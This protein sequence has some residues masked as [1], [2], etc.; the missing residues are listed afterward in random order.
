MEEKNQ[1]IKKYLEEIFP[2]EEIHCKGNTIKIITKGNNREN[3]C[4]EL[5]SKGFLWKESS[6]SSLGE[7]IKDGIKILIKP[8]EYQGIL[9][10]G[11]FNEYVF[12][13][14]INSV[15][16][17]TSS[18]SVILSSSKY[19]INYSNIIRCNDSSQ[20]NTKKYQKSD[21]SLIGNNNQIVSNIS[22]KKHKSFWESCKNRFRDIYDFFI[23][24]GL[25]NSFREIEFREIKKDKYKL[26]NPSNQQPYSRIY[27]DTTLNDKSIKDICFGS[28]EISPLIIKHN[29]DTNNKIEYNDDKIIIYSDSIFID[30]KDVIENNCKPVLC[31]QH[32]INKKYGIDFRAFPEQYITG[33]NI[34]YIK[35][36]KR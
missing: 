21:V 7:F 1:K 22:L 2:D 33:G 8:K 23:E 12:S 14:N 28:E 3:I 4:D 35:Y 24:E 32:N 5:K 31:F 9:S 30:V 16:N 10:H 20:N 19:E 15:T 18:Y 6:L 26:I 13:N 36:E 29:F 11:K 27:V 34:T 25:K 17:Y